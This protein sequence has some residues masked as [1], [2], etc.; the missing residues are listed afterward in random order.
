VKRNLL[1]DFVGVLA[2][3]L[4][5]HGNRVGAV[6]YG[7]AVQGVIPERNGKAQVLHLI[8]TL[9][10]QPQL[11]RT[12]PTDLSILLNASLRILRR[13]SLVF[14]ISDFISQPGWDKSLGILSQRHEVIAVRL[15]DPREIELP[16]IGPVYMEDAE[17][18]EQIYLDTHDKGFRKRFIEAARRREWELRSAFSRAGVDALS[19]STE[20]DLI[21]EIVRFATLRK[22]RGIIARSVTAPSAKPLS[23]RGSRR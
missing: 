18:G 14:L 19:L 5:R 11:H 13:R 23:S 2:R 3:L 6:L 16:D 7:G 1:V 20:S 12:P 22:Q 8:D 15:Y 17:T 9:L 10:Q 4:S 21:K